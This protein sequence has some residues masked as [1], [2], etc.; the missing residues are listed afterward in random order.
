MV[1]IYHFGSDGYIAS[2]PVV[3]N[4]WLFVD[5]FFVLSGFVIA[6]SYGQRLA[7][8]EVSVWRFMG[9]RMGRIYPLHIAVLLGFVS[10]EILLIVAGDMLSSYVSRD[11][12]TG[13]RSIESLVQNLFLLQSFAIPGG[14]GWNGPAWSIAAEMWT[15]LLFA[16]VFLAGRRGLLLISILLAIASLTWMTSYAPDLHI[17]F[18]GGVL[19][20]VFGFAIGVLTYN[21][22]QR[23]G[24]VGGSAWEI[25]AVLVTLA[26]VAIAEGTVTFAAPLVFGGM[27]FVLASQRGALAKA[28]SSRPFQQ[29]GLISY[30]IYM[31]HIFVQA[32]FGEILQIADVVDLSVDE[33]GRTL[34]MGAPW[35]GDLLTVVMVA[36]VI[37]ALFFSYYLVEKPG[38][39]L[40]RRWLS[41]KA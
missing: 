18:H 22:F 35:I 9:L 30:S 6:H 40:S 2:L 32:R 23:F 31:V 39:D 15:Y 16:L 13:S 41:R 19:R 5:Y 28:L 17:T 12:F 8:R 26:F 7:D 20:C 33:A 14:H 27:I 11:P 21:A 4:G 34:T 24:G 1:A 3:Q 10:L 38:R 25:A 37:I 29:L 36:L